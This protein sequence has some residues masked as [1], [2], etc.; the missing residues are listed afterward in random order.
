M[1]TKNI[2][3]EY[4]KEHLTNPIIQQNKFLITN[5][6]PNIDIEKAFRLEFS[7]IMYC[8]KGKISFCHNNIN[9][10]LK[11][12]MIFSSMPNSVIENILL[13]PHCEI[14]FLCFT[15]SFMSMML[16]P[17]EEIYS[18][19]QNIKKEPILNLTN[20]LNT[21]MDYF[22]KLIINSSNL[23]DDYFRNKIITNLINAL[24]LCILMKKFENN[25]TEN[26]EEPIGNQGVVNGILKR[27]CELLA[28]DSGKHRTVNYYAEKMCISPKY[29]SRIV[30]KLTHK[31][32][33]DVI[34]KHAIEKIE[35][36]LLHT[37]KSAKEISDELGFS[38]PSFFGKFVKQ[39]LGYNPNEYREKKL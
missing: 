8:K 27:F 25:Y 32:T 26:I 28:K 2:S 29:L 30:K 14:Y 11:D 4:L 23:H 13:S 34:N 39:H 15:E 20:E 31:K 35:F 21:N 5:E 33:I 24:M 19:I 18:A 16:P 6:I 1:A 10:T 22:T 17:G 37:S 9:F 7:Y 36:Y 12:K 38:S 3:F